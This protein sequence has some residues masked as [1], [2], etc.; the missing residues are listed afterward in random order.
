[1]LREVDE[2]KG[3]LLLVRVGL[4]NHKNRLLCDGIKGEGPKINHLLKNGDNFC[5]EWNI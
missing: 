1:M 3:D 2:V 5:D 4:E